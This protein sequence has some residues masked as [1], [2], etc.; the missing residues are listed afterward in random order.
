MTPTPRPIPGS[1]PP[2]ILILG[3]G[4]NTSNRGVA[5]LACGTLASIYHSFPDAHVALLDYAKAPAS[6]V[7]RH[8]ERTHAIGL[9]P[10]RFSKNP[11]HPNHV[12]RLVL[13]AAF[14]RWLPRAG[15]ARW[16][17]GNPWLRAIERADIIGALS[18]GDSFS[19]LYGLRRLLYV[20][21]PQLLVLAL[22]RPLTLL[23]QSY[24]PFR[25]RSAGWL[26]GYILRR[27]SSIHSRDTEGLTTIRR[28][29]PTIGTRAAFG[30]D[31]GF[32][33]E[34]RLPPA[35]VLLPLQRAKRLRP[36]AGLNISGLLHGDG[37]A[38]TQDFGLHEPYGDLMFDTIVHLVR[39]IGA[40][41][42]LIPHVFGRN[43]ESD[44]TAAAK[45][46]RRLPAGI[47]AQVVLIDRDLDQHEVKSVIGQC[48]LFIGARMHACIAALS[49]AVPTVALAY[50][51]KFLGVLQSIDS[52][53][54]VVDLRLESRA[55]VLG[56]IDS[57]FA[58]RAPLQAALAAR[59]P[60]VRE[61]VLGFFR[62][63]QSPAVAPTRLPAG[64]ILPH[65]LNAA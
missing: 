45:L 55:E 8:G 54:R 61:S 2:E 21:L 63:L 37:D 12:L 60:I 64:S 34:P 29:A 57:T 26:A 65:G 14:L 56:A 58:A 40:T 5:A 33:L 16:I 18:G 6:Q 50:S 44:L 27:A 22:G 19:D 24:G 47:A 23:P 30:Y 10:L 11:F 13:L 32:A 39:Q 1:T 51:H 62:H 36:L 31:M 48:D 49:Q 42:V 53:H 46:W 52:R 43:G 17:A 41:V 28:L 9:I 7:F 3:A 38:G 4:F 15:R 25:R 20:S 35:A 59:A